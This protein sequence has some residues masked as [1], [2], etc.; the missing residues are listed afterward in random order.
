MDYK[1]Q[2]EALKNLEAIAY[3][4]NINGEVLGMDCSDFEQI[5]VDA[6]ESITDLL[7]R[8]EKAE[9]ALQNANRN[10]HALQMDVIRATNRAEETEPEKQ[11][12]C[13]EADHL[14]DLLKEAEARA[15]KAERCITEIKSARDH[16]RPAYVVDQILEEY[17]T[18]LKGEQNG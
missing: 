11:K 8:A 16:T 12:L 15:E 9:S 3:G 14:K 17:H 18:A 1:E 6:A 7:S 2:V 5:M 4:Y 10:I 13:E